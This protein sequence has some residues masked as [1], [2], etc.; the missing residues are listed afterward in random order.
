M[1]G[2]VDVAHMIQQRLRELETQL[3][4][5][6]QLARERERLQRAL[7]VLVSDDGAHRGRGSAQTPQ[8]QEIRSSSQTQKFGI[9]GR[10]CAF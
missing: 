3:S 4:G 8:Q 10:S 7:R 5:F 2:L 1:A 6:E 9:V